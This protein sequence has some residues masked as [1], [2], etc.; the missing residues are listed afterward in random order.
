MLTRRL[1]VIAVPDTEA[2]GAALNAQLTALTALAR[3]GATTV[4]PV[5]PADGKYVPVAVSGASFYV[6]AGELLEG[7]DPAKESARLAA[8]IAK[9]DKEL[10]GVNGRLGNPSFVERA[11]PEVVERTRTDA[12]DLAARRTKLEARRGLLG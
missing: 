10:A 1:T 5:A 2:A 8:E 12:A 9:L 3:L 4:A 6:P 7:L 11:L